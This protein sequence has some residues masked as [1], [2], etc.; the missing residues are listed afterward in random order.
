MTEPVL[1][2]V[3]ELEKQGWKR[4]GYAD[5]D[6]GQ[7]MIGDP[8]YTLPRKMDEDLG[9]DYDELIDR[10]PY[11][12]PGQTTLT[13]KPDHA[14]AGIVMHT[15]FGDGT[16][17]VLIREHDYGPGGMSGIRVIE[18]RILFVEKASEDE[19]V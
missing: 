4:V 15:G 12:K 10:W 3:E 19:D 18:A 14:G 16:Y 7:I 8:C 1:T 6:S 9:L 17:P 11:D 5:V 2:C 13:A